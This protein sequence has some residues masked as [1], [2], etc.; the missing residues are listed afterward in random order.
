MFA[1]C[2]RDRR[3]RLLV[4]TSSAIAFG[5]SQHR[6]CRNLH[7]GKRRTLFRDVATSSPFFPL[8]GLQRGASLYKRFKVAPESCKNGETSSERFCG[9]RSQQPVAILCSDTVNESS[10]QTFSILR[11]FFFSSTH[12][13]IARV[14]R[15]G[16]TQPSPCPHSRRREYA[17]RRVARSVA[18]L[19]APSRDVIGRI[20]MSG[21]IQ[22]RY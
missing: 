21:C 15:R 14:L 22:E 12:N 9:K 4:A 3:S 8:L 6:R 7:R 20:Q 13:R 16:R 5:R 18:P 17:K 10:S 11:R 1:E 19:P 2:W